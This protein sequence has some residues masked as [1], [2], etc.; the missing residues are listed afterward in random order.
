MMLKL[1]CLSLQHIFKYL[2]A[3]AIKKDKQDFLTGWKGLFKMVNIYNFCL[4][5]LLVISLIC[6]GDRKA[7]R[8]VFLGSSILQGV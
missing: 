6:G 7:A 4:F 3:E 8:C 2:Q 1:P 5:L